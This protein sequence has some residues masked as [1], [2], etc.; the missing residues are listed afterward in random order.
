[1]A[2]RRFMLFI[3]VCFAAVF[4]LFPYSVWL[5]PFIP[6]GGADRK[7]FLAFHFPL[8]LILKTAAADKFAQDRRRGYLVGG[9]RLLYA[10]QQ[11]PLDAAALAQRPPRR[12]EAHIPLSGVCRRNIQ[13]VALLRDI[14]TAPQGGAHPARGARHACRVCRDQATAQ[15]PR[16]L[17]PDLSRRDPAHVAPAG[18]HRRQQ[19]QILIPNE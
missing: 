17:H 5:F 1:M 4:H 12:G 7:F 16:Q 11:R 9:A 6:A 18:V 13:L 8:P 10:R 14:G 19:F 3:S 2:R 15:V